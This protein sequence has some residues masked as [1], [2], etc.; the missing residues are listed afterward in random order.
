MIS[1]NII[2]LGQVDSTNLYAENLLRSGSIPEGTVIW[3]HDQAEG[4]GQDSNT[5]ESEPGKNLTMSLVLHPEFVPIE[6]QF[7]LNKVVSLGTLDFIRE[8]IPGSRCSLKWPNDLYAGDRKLGGILIRNAVCGNVMESSIVGIGI[9]INQEK[10]SD[11]LPNPVSIKI[12]TGR[13][14]EIKSALNGLCNS[15]NTRYLQLRT[16]KSHDIDTAYLENLLGFGTW[17]NYSKGE[18][19]IEGRIK[20]VS[21]FGHLLLE[22]RKDHLLSFDHKEIGY[23]F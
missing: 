3:A 16:G 23:I 18:E 6:N 15:L 13:E 5:W 14:F 21:R 9:N 1:F 20:G 11:A 10:F 19:I 22:T 7:M 4:R 2:E 8:L 17:R 12:L